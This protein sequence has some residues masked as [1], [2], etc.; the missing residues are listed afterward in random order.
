MIPER[1]P[2]PEHFGHLLLVLSTILPVPLQQLQSSLRHPM[3]V[4]PLPDIRVRDLGKS[5]R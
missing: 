4:P 3:F 1:H 2:F 5:R